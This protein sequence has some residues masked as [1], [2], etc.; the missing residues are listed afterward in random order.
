MIL[1][2]H[3]WYGF[4]FILWMHSSFC[5][6][7]RRTFGKPHLDTPHC[8]ERYIVS[9][10]TFIAAV[11]AAPSQ[12]QVCTCMCLSANLC[13]LSTYTLFPRVHIV[14]PELLLIDCRGWTCMILYVL[15]YFLLGV[16]VC[17]QWGGM[18]WKD[19]SREHHCTELSSVGFRTWNF[20]GMS[21][22]TIFERF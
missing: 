8:I 18:H 13:A 4:D 12:V 19:I 7:W 3:A 6:Q 5:G 1:F 2:L 15:M 9:D 22:T 17:A 20:P 14:M 21:P 11:S 10:D 16:C